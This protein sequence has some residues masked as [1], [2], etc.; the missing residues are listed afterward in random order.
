MFTSSGFV[1][2]WFI[3]TQSTSWTI[4]RIAFFGSEV[5]IFIY[6]KH[7]FGS[8]FSTNRLTDLPSELSSLEHLQIINLSMNKYGCSRN[9]AKNNKIFC[10]RFVR[11]PGVLYELKQIQE[12]LA[13]DN[14]LVELDASGILKISTTICTFNVRNNNIQR[15]P[16]ELSKCTLL[17]SLDVA[18]KYSFLGNENCE[19]V[20]CFPR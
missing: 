4:E 17:K 8:V 2:Q 11:L 6:S 14:Q 20:F 3:A 10:V 18:G 12:I 1:Y 5:G 16:P 15:L 19:V 7:F 9:S 13:N